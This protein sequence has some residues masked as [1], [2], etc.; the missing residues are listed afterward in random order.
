MQKIIANFL[1]RN[2]F[3]SILYLRSKCQS[4]FSFNQGRKKNEEPRILI[5]LKITLKL[6]SFDLG[7]IMFSVVRN[8][9]CVSYKVET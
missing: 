9:T 6:C 3:Y 1:V 2:N 4:Y 7:A 8:D 5:I